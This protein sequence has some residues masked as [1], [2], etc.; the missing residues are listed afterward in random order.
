M[1][2]VDGTLR[3]GGTHEYVSVF[4]GPLNDL[5]RACQI[6]LDVDPGLSLHG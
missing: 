1:H 5:G 2:P 3:S 4:E 6:D